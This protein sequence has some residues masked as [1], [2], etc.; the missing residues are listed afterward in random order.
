LSL[1]TK[2]QYDNSRPVSQLVY[3]ANT[4]TVTIAGIQ[5]NVGYAG[6]VIGAAGLYQLNVTVPPNIGPGDQPV[7]IAVLGRSTPSA[8]QMPVYLNIA[9]S[10]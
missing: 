7:T 6:M 8:S 10:Q 1:S 4:P 2:P 9:Q 3:L 5:A